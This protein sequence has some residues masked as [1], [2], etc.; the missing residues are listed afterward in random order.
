[1]GLDVLGDRRI[2]DPRTQRSAH[3]DD[4]EPVLG[5]AELGTGAGPVTC[6]VNLHDRPAE[7]RTGVHGVRERGVREGDSARCCAPRS[8][9][10]RTTGPLVVADH[11]DRDIELARGQRRREACIAA[12]RDDDSGCEFAKQANRLP[13]GAMQSDE[14]RDVVDDAL[15]GERPPEADHV[16]EGVRKAG[17]RQEIDLNPA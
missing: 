17:R 2:Q 14:E 9:P 1:M 10:A 13:A 8:E 7:W 16:E 3:H 5:D 15:P 11:H 12:D 4:E 6:A